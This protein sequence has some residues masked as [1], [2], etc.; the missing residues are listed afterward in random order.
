MG[1]VGWRRRCSATPNFRA[2][3]VRSALARLL[4]GEGQAERRAA[5]AYRVIEDEVAAHPAHERTRDIE[6][7]AAAV[8]AGLA[9]RTTRE[10]A[11]QPGSIAFREAWTDSRERRPKGPLGRFDPDLD[12]DRPLSIL[13]G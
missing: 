7:E 4:A 12:G 10:A 11:Q 3:S 5:S 8:A 9:R 2:P 13:D 6:A 1:H